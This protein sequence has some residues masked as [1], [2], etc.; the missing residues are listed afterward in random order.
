MSLSRK[1]EAGEKSE[2]ES[3][4]DI[5]DDGRAPTSV[6]SRCFS[7]DTSGENGSVR[8]GC[9]DSYKE[10]RSDENGH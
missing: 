4:G 6:P 2:D 10:L 1:L 9:D 3:R 7:G 8:F 5:H